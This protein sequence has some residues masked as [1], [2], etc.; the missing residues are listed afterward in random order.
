MEEVGTVVRGELGLDETHTHPLVLIGTWCY[1]IF[2]QGGAGMGDL[3]LE[4]IDPNGVPAQRDPDQG[5]SASLGLADGVCPY[6][7][8]RYTLQVHAAR[9]QG[10]YAFRVFRKQIL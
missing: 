3:E 9:G 1:R 2:A 10:A 5:P 6:Y 7:A 4:L 8:G